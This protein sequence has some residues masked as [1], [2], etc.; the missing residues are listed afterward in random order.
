MR[1]LRL[2]L[3]VM[4][5]L[6][7]LLVCAATGVLIWQLERLSRAHTEREL[8]ETARAMSLAVDG[9]LQ[10]YQGILGALLQSEALQR[11]DWPAFDA[12]ARRLLSGPDV[13]IALG[14][15][16]D[17]QRVNTLLPRGATLPKGHLPDRVWS[18][19]DR[20]QT[21]I[22]D[23]SHGLVEPN[24]LCVDA[25]VMRGGRAAYHLTIVFKPQAL[26]S[27]VGSQRPTGRRFASVIDGNGVLIWRNTD[28]ERYLGAVADQRMLAALGRAPSGVMNSRSLNGVPTLLAYARSPISGWS[29]LVAIPRTEAGAAGEKAL[30][31]GIVGAAILLLLGVGTGLVAGGR[32]SDAVARLSHAAERARR[33]EPAAFRPSGLDEIDAVGLLLDEAIAARDASQERFNL[34]Q[35]IGGIGAW[36]WDVAKDEGHV[37]G[38]YKQMHGLEGAPGPLNLKQVLGVIHPDDLSGY[39]ERLNAATRRREAST[40]NYRVVLPDGSIRWI[41]AKGRPLFDEA[42]TFARALGIVRDVTAE[43]EASAAIRA[44]EQRLALALAAGRMA[45]WEVD[46][47]GRLTPN[48]AINQLAG[49]PPE[50]EPTLAELE[51]NY[52]PG[53]VDRIRAEAE[54]ALARG[55]PF[56]DVEY[57][58]RRTDGEVRWFNARAELRRTPSGEPEGAIGIVL[59]VTERKLSEERLRLL[60]REVDHRA[61]NLMA[62]VQGAVRLSRGAD[63]AALQEIIIGRVHALARAHQLLADSRWEGADLKR[64]VED[65]IAAFTLGEGE[66]VHVDGGPLSLP[67]AAAQGVAMA[68]HEL[69][70]NAAKHGA[71][72]TADGHVEIAW[73]V[74]DGRLR[75]RWRETGGPPVR[76]PPTRGFGM[77]VLRR[78]VAGSLRGSTR[79]DWREEG[80]V[81]ELELPLGQDQ[82]DAARA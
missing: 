53:E 29:F 42:G 54:A 50:A 81:C 30:S 13:W 68:L 32:V 40:N 44:S 77:T 47:L 78:A 56:F 8:L 74:E 61:N 39:I 69:A 73:K 58:Y 49:L 60:T 23:L 15:R 82:L 24:I 7:V 65:E 63:V 27:I 18:I 1:S 72:S 4:A 12:Q 6:L 31:Y 59:D 9:R 52:L 45:V 10:S 17:H 26:A 19:L 2:Y 28:P 41:S 38:G 25:P 64:L 3:V 21:H 46:G 55:E 33:G 51:P 67:P 11:E 35:E 5:S 34:A 22:C 36:E 71:L 75:L 66:R 20:G 37:S 62:V 57:R 70:T 80:L 43:H 16:R 14:D 48:P 79:L 76:E